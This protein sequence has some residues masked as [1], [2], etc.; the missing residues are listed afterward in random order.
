MLQMLSFDYVTSFRLEFLLLIFL[1]RFLF[2]CLKVFLCMF[3]YKK[4]FSL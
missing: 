2:V 3:N 4:E 1:C